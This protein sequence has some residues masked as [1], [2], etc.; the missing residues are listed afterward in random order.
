MYMYSS[1]VWFSATLLKG[2]LVVAMTTFV[3]VCTNKHIF[4]GSTAFFPVKKRYNSTRIVISG[5][6]VI[7][8]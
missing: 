7:N 2:R 1:L 8:G 6:L 3:H 4:S 5:N